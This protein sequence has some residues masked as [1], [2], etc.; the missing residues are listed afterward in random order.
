MGYGLWA[1]AF[2]GHHDCSQWITSNMRITRCPVIYILKNRSFR[3][4]FYFKIIK[5][6]LA[7]GFMA[8]HQILRLLSQFEEALGA[9]AGYLVSMPEPKLHRLKSMYQR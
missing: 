9:H 4:G 5:M 6:A 2:L 7:L 1:M 8:S 3:C